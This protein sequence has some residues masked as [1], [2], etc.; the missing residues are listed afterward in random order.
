MA[1]L[2][3]HQCIIIIIIII[4]ITIIVVSSSLAIRSNVDLLPVTSDF[5]S[6]FQLR[7]SA[8]IG[9]CLYTIPPSVFLVVLLVDFPDDYF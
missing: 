2:H 3:E 7:N 9:V 8:F 6:V 1:N 4:I 5:L